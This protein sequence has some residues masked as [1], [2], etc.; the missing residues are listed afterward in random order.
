MM[1]RQ[2][3]EYVEYF[4]EVASMITNDAR[5]KREITSRIAMAK[6][7]FNKNQKYSFHQQIGLKVKEETF[8]MPHM[9]YSLVRV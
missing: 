9:E 7:A 2:Q 3:L 8:K 5:Y 4:S 6:A 1:D